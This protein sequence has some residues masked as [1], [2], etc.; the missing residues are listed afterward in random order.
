M[1]RL[2]VATLMSS[3]VGIVVAFGALSSVNSCSLFT[4][5][6]DAGGGGGGGESKLYAGLSFAL[7]SGEGSLK[8]PSS[9]LTELT[10]LG[11]RDPSPAAAIFKETLDIFFE[12]F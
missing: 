9:V 8:P 7:I 11:G 2:G 12:R 1:M 10:I 4:S 5:I 3:G 6:V